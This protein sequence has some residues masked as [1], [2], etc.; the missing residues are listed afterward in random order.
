MIRAR[1]D[2]ANAR[3]SAEEWLSRYDTLSVAN[4]YDICGFPSEII[5]HVDNNW[6]WR[7]GAQFD[8]RRVR[9]GYILVF[10]RPTLLD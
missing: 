4:L 9:D 3:D 2:A 10:P 7:I 1:D 6:G 8:I 5:D